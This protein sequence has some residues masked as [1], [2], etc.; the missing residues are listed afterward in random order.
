MG[1]IAPVSVDV[2]TNGTIVVNALTITGAISPVIVNVYTNGSVGTNKSY[3]GLRHVTPNS[4]A[5]TPQLPSNI[6]ITAMCD[7][8]TSCG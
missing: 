6:R 3:T 2:Y 1:D 8:V 7:S 5:L 4:R